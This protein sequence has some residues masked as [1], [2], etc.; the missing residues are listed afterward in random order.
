MQFEP[1]RERVWKT[2][3]RFIFLSS[4]LVVRNDLAM[5]RCTGL[6][7]FFMPAVQNDSLVSKY[8]INARIG[9]LFEPTY[10]ALN[11]IHLKIL[12][13]LKNSIHQHGCIT[14]KLSGPDIW[15]SEKWIEHNCT[16]I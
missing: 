7:E 1:S 5:V 15:S 11:Q 2:F 13:H 3:W 9:G 4:M 16:C 12:M 14:Q 10:L 8:A 6:D